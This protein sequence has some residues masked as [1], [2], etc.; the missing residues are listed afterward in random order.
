MPTILLIRHGENDFVKKG[1]MPGRMP[2]IHLNDNGRAQAQAVA[3]KLRQAPIKAIYTSPLERAAETAEYLAKALG[4]ET[5]VRPGLMESDIGEWQGKSHKSLRRLKA[6]RIVQSTPSLF[7]F[8]GGESFAECQARMVGEIETLRAQYEEK[9]IFVCVSHADPIKL[10][11]AY[12]LGLPL[13]LFQRL[14]IAPA[15]IT[16]LQVGQMG[17]YLL[18][19]NYDLSFNLSKP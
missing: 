1:I 5:I 19:L 7:R 13:D 12:Y 18:A 11:V 4:Q 16:A 2:G 3:E 10:A 9:D 17:S 6:W 15:S 8:P 14:F